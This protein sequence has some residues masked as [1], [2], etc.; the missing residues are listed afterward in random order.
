MMPKNV[1]SFMHFKLFFV[2][3][4]FCTLPILAQNS[5]KTD[6]LL[7]LLKSGDYTGKKEIILLAD[8]AHYHPNLDTSILF[9]NK[10][11]QKAQLL[12]APLLEA[13]ALE[14]ISHRERKLGNNN[15]SFEATFRALQIYESLG[16]PERQAASYTQLA[17]NYMSNNNYLKAIHYLK[18]SKSSYEASNKNTKLNYTI[19]NLGEMY[20]LVGYLDSAIVSFREVLDKNKLLKDDIAQCY[21]Q[22]NLGM[23]YNSLDS[24]DLAKTH[25]KEAITILNELDDPYSTSVYLAELG[26][27]Y[28]KEG[29]SN[30]AEEKLLQA[31]RMAKQAGLR[32][33][34][35]D[36]SSTLSSFYEEQQH[37]SEAL[38]YQ[39]MFQVYQDSL[40]NKKNIQEV[41][42]LKSR[43][44]IDKRESEIG[45]LNSVN[46]N[47]KYFLGILGGGILTTILFLY[48][49]YTRN[50]NIK[51]MN[52]A[53]LIQKEI[54]SKR[55]QEKALLLGELNHRVKNNLQMISSLLS[56]QSAELQGHPALEAIVIGK[57]RVDALS[58]VHKKLYQ[59]GT[60]TR[61]K[62]KEYI[63]ELVLSLFH[64]YDAGFEPT[65]EI[66]D[67]SIHVDMAIPL[68][69]I[70]NEVTVNA[71]KYAY[72]NI[73]HPLL[74]IRITQEAT[75]SLK[76]QII[77]NGVG[78]SLEEM[79]KNNA[80]GIK[81]IHSLIEQLEGTIQKSDGN[82][83]H[84]NMNVKLA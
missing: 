31:L 83:S 34:I 15:T 81:L 2:V 44:E 7:Q 79:E 74:K 40:V 35:R 59:E 16:L 82:G 32:E 30:L 5:K 17:N 20:R 45:L 50:K 71:L 63:E 26:T 57:H 21:S 68:G 67:I 60:T 12:N 61:I 14:I 69:L 6:S 56:L 41:E 28:K 37:Y 9:A 43:Y 77:D 65:F 18:K 73:A 10:S 52:L 51:K 3:V 49:F 84:W 72:S 29:N 23:V 22:G 33:Q 47:Q 19:L 8:I 1:V 80:F 24:L 11:L 64:G 53:L 55:E 42:Q 58:L 36:F 78:F 62:I 46:L 13:E 54:V 66:D 4:A 39:R 38:T 27:I 75:N 76:M 70:L 25:L 48:F